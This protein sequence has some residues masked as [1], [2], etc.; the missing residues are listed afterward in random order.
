MTYGYNVNKLSYCN[1][2]S[3][4]ENEMKVMTIINQC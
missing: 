2:G 4:S 3:I 1:L